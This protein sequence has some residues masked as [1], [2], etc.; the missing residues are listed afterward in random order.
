SERRQP[1]I[2][3]LGSL[4]GDLSC[5]SHGSSQALF[6]LGANAHFNCASQFGPRFLRTPSLTGT[7]QSSLPPRFG[8]ESAIALKSTLCASLSPAPCGH[9]RKA[10]IWPGS[11]RRAFWGSGYA[12]RG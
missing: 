6:P 1:V 12:Q 4:L 5:I 11:G 8:P 3:L 7:W 9:A 2:S 10:A